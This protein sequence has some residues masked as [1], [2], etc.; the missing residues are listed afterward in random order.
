MGQ[1]AGRPAHHARPHHGRRRGRL[2]NGRPN[3][4]VTLS[5]RLVTSDIEILQKAAIRGVGVAQL[6]EYLRAAAIADGRLVRLMPDL[7]T[8]AGT[9]YAVFSRE[10]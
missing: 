6:R 4:L 2:E 9:V 8:V 10:I 3:H 5:P 1:R 7:T